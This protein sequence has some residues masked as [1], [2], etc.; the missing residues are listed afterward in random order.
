MS[1][2]PLENQRLANI[3]GASQQLASPVDKLISVPVAQLKAGRQQPRTHFDEESLEKLTQSVRERGVLQ[4]LLV[5]QKPRGG[6]EIVAGERRWRAAQQAGLKEVPVIVRDLTDQEAAVIALVENLQREDLNVMDEVDGKLRLIASA[7]A[8][9]A[10]QVPG[11]LN[12]L[13]RNPHPEDIQALT[14]LFASLGES[15]ESFAKNKL[16]ILNYPPHLV[17]ALRRGMALT[18]VTLIARAPAKHQPALL[19]Q[20]EA[21]AGRKTIAEQVARL[22]KKPRPR[23]E[24]QVSQV[25]S[26]PKWL[27]QLE[28][29]DAE[30]VQRWLQQMPAALRTA[31]DQQGR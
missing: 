19:E 12:E 8:L 3:L 28:P 23:L 10:E 15:W 13:R 25:L 5:R 6:Y 2:N 9:P 26:N 29:R 17:A 16:R 1:R 22:S 27:S 21:G 7:L 18:M 4:P 31:L 14:T 24:Q 11:R 30:A 20:A